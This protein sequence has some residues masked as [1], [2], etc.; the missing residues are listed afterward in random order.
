VA[1][2]LYLL[3]YPII[4]FLAYM[5]FWLLYRLAD[6][7]YIIMYKMIGYRKKVV[8]KNLKLV[9]PEKTEEERQ[10][11]EQKFYRHF[12]DLFVE[13]VK[14]FRMPL[15]Q[16]QKRFVF[17]NAGLLNE[18]TAKNQ[19]IIVVGGHYANWEWIFSLAAMTEAFP[20]ATY[21]KINNPYFEKFMLKNRQR[22]GGKLIETKELKHS[23]Q[24]FSI[25]QEKF[26]LGLLADQSPQKHR[27]KYWRSFLG[28][29]NV[30][31]H[32]G[33]ENLAKRYNAAYVFMNIQKV[34]RGHYE[35]TFELITNEPGKFAN[36]QLTD[37]YLD[38]L[39][40]QIRQEP[41]YYLWTHN[42]FK[43]RRKNL[44]KS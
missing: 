3:L 20:I 18:I 14:A 4:I 43:H 37:H 10:K 40:K 25:N 23:L 34:K 16:M 22:F 15:S 32:I 27:A 8:R 12:A 9:F 42:R 35:V 5:P 17:K 24:T 11:I 6:F 30:P 26:I 28:V 41:A 19:N 29:D 38:K 2:F 31:V 39:E 1:Y 13:M 44:P 33:P 36:Y 7:L 21:L